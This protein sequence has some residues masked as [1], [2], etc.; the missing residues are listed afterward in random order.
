MLARYRQIGAYHRRIKS[1]KYRWKSSNT[2]PF[3]MSMC[4]NRI[5]NGHRTAERFLSQ[6]LQYSLSP[7]FY[8][9][10]IVTAYA[11]A[12]LLRFDFRLSSEA[13]RSLIATLPAVLIA[14]LL[15]FWGVGHFSA[16]WGHVSFRELR[17][18]STSVTLSAVVLL[19][20]NQ[21]R[22]RSAEIPVSIFAIDAAATLLLI[23]AVRAIFRWRGEST[24]GGPNR[25]P[26]KNAFLVGGGTA[27]KLLALQLECNPQLGLKIS[28]FLDESAAYV[29]QSVGGV[30]VLGTLD[31]V[32]PMA[33]QRGVRDVI[34]IVG[35]LPAKQLRQLRESCKEAGLCVHILPPLK[36]LIGQQTH[37]PLHAIDVETLLGR[38]P[39]TLDESS[40]F[41]LVSG[42]TV[43]VTGAG[44]SIG[45]ELCRQLVKFRP[46][47]VVLVDRSEPSL[48]YIH[49]ELASQGLA[50]E[51]EPCLGDVTDHSRIRQIFEEHQPDMVFHVAAHKH[52]PL[53]ETHVREAVRN[54]VLGTATLADMANAFN[55]QRFVYIST[56]K[57]VNPS[58][59]M[60][61][62]KRLAEQYVL[63]LAEESA[64]R[65]VAVR[66]GNVLGSAGSV[67]PLFQEQ[68]RRGGPITITHPEMNRF[69]MTIAEAARLVLQAA[70]VGKGGEVFVL[71]MGEPV[72]IVDLAR[73]M[74]AQA[75]LPEHA[76]DM[77]F[78]GLRP[79]EKLS[80]ELFFAHEERLAT[81]HAKLFSVRHRGL[82]LAT[83][84][85]AL[86]E[87][88]VLVERREVDALAKLRELVPEYV[89][90]SERVAQSL[91]ATNSAP[92][93]PALN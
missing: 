34:A 15:V 7:L 86:D 47:K 5:A 66:F 36:Q 10:L 87:L 68:I 88:H 11:A 35:S 1:P 25:A 31:Q 9:C 84:R 54:N 55:V 30:P 19:G 64:G 40:A 67:V 44:G 72:R 53:L 69:F 29:G 3:N 83:L 92:L 23:G 41:E 90:P 74:I 18:L 2:G 27:E 76:I 93:T 12:F 6:L 91:A 60:G 14:K 57:A 52:V 50:C 45:S 22:W 78:V 77:S 71:D 37:L 56:D 59:V 20:F 33:R 61:A 46:R 13:A 75:G 51:I 8:G 80:E 32:I 16:W 49:L 24:G 79:G 89:S 42:Q 26:L 17:L 81:P 65:F 39:V 48:F 62:T 43:L 82:P 70:A 28:G 21:L 63:A 85:R 58:S 38:P 73:A 4:E